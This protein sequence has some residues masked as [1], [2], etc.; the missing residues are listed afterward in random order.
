MPRPE[1]Y[2]IVFVFK[3]VLVFF[4]P[5]THFFIVLVRLFALRVVCL[6]WS[7]FPRNESLSPSLSADCTVYVQDRRLMK[8]YCL[9]LLVF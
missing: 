5:W 6:N 4:C 1:T 2:Y 3:Y 8:L 9:F 7:P